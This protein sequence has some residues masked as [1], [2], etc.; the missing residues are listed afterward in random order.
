MAFVYVGCLHVSVCWIFEFVCACR[1]IVCVMC[2]CV[3]TYLVIYYCVRGV[4][5]QGPHL[6][7]F[8]QNFSFN[9]S[10]L[11]IHLSYLC[12]PVDPFLLL[13]KNVQ[14]QHCQIDSEISNQSFPSL[15]S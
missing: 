2:I 1:V 3:I 5:A 15:L 12:T 8:F 13:S 6:V 9:F 11:S 7:T 10:V 14:Y 4:Y